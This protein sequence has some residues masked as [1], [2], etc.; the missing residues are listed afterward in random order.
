[1]G[2]D[3][4]IKSVEAYL[5]EFI[6]FL[7][8]FFFPKSR[9][10]TYDDANHTAVF[11]ILS[12]VLGAYLWYHYIAPDGG[13]GIDLLSTVIDSLLRW[14]S[15]GVALYALLVVLTVEATFMHTVL[16]T[17]K[18]ISIAHI[19]AIY[20]G[21]LAASTVWY[22]L[23]HESAMLGVYI[24]YGFEWI[25]VAIYI[26]REA[27]PAADD[28]RNQLWEVL[29]ARVLFMT[30]FTILAVMP[31]KVRHDCYKYYVDKY[32]QFLSGQVQEADYPPLCHAL[33]TQMEARRKRDEAAK[34]GRGAQP[35]T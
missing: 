13:A 21:Y 32:P 12:S 1:M 6:A 2:L 14:F 16:G 11:A 20:L 19:V 31:L 34:A 4:I 23:P 25:F 28:R 30:I 7:A 22:F 8:S 3:G 27:I 26:P 17:M 33:V 35:E 18:V 15:L 9:Q 5:R 10:Q 29:A 24:A